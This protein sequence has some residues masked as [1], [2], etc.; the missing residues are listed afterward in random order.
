MYLGLVFP[1]GAELEFRL[2]WFGTGGVGTGERSQGE[3]VGREEAGTWDHPARKPGICPGGEGACKAER[4][5]VARGGR[6][7]PG[8]GLC[9]GEA[10][11]VVSKCVSSGGPNASRGRSEHMGRFNS[12][13]V[14][15]NL[16]FGGV[17]RPDKK[18]YLGRLDRAYIWIQKEVR[19][20]GMHGEGRGWGERERTAVFPRTHAASAAR[21]PGLSRAVGFFVPRSPLLFL[22]LRVCS[23]PLLSTLPRL[24]LVALTT[25]KLLTPGLPLAQ[26]LPRPQLSCTLATFP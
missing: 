16:G 4:G 20:E 12:V 26:P 2:K 22:C 25:H 24:P 19:A 11:R 5:P 3:T 21:P 7:K 15:G 9:S 6:R 18:L 23:H 14:L 8:E 1:G 13:D 10:G 17:I